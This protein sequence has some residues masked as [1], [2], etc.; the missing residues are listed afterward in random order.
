MS[1]ENGQSSG[2]MAQKWQAVETYTPDDPENDR[3]RQTVEF[4][5]DSK[6][7]LEIAA[8]AYV[9]L[10]GGTVEE[11]KEELVGEDVAD[12]LD[13]VDVDDEDPD[14]QGFEYTYFAR[15]GEY[16]VTVDKVPAGKRKRYVTVKVRYAIESD[17]SVEALETHYGQQVEVKLRE[18][19]MAEGLVAVESEVS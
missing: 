17:E 5:T 8:H 10:H 12:Q 19:G 9:A 1:N 16:S 2:I 7:P 18:A 14:A 4:E 6:D 13:G 11:A 15:N 3:R